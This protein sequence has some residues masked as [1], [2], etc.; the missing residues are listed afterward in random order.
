[1]TLQGK[2]VFVTGAASGIGAAT[3]ELFRAQG[4]EV[5]GVDITEVEGL[6]ACDVSDPESVQCAI[7]QAVAQLGGLDIVANVAGVGGMTPLAEMPLAH[8]EKVMG[9]NVTGPMLVTKAALPHLA[10]SKGNVV[11]VA[12]ISG[13]QGQPYMSAYCASKAALLHFMKSIAV[14][15]A[16]QH[17]RVNCVCP[18]GVGQLPEV[19]DA[20]QIVPAGVDPALFTRLNPVLPGVIEPADIA[21][22]LAYLASDA[23]RSITGAA[24]L[25][26]R[27]TLW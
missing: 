3:V 5:V 20:E 6:L 4:A 10:A 22:A 15:L 16:P 27:G 2:R 17:V 13:I 1:M 11:S 19:A 7:D 14:E 26:D 23:A 25:V 21:D 18:G 24:L 8:W 12:S 9:V